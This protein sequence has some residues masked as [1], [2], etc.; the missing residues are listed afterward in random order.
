VEELIQEVED[1]CKSLDWKYHV[2]VRRN[3]TKEIGDTLNYTPE[4]LKGISISPEECE[5]VDLTFL[6]SGILCSVVKLIY[7]NPATNDLMIEVIST[8]TQF[9]GLDAHKAVVN[10]LR[11]LSEKYFSEFE[12]SDEGMYW[13]TKDEEKLR[14]QFDRYNFILDAV[15]E[16][17]TDFKSIPGET[18]M[19]LADRLE[20]FLIKKLGTDKNG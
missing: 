14:S 3:F 2:W 1:I 15:T 20:E 13:E 10:L 8:K 17:L 12:L 6:P 4:D 19:S 18:P 7:N 16:A 9:A 5:P 11:Y